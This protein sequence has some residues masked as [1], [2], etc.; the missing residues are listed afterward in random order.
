MLA[1]PDGRLAVGLSTGEILILLAEIKGDPSPSRALAPSADTGTCMAVIWGIT[2]RLSAHSAGVHSLAL[3]PGS[4]EA[5]T[6]VVSSAADQQ[7]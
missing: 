3:W 2:A 5:N 6:V 7:V 4:G 1:L